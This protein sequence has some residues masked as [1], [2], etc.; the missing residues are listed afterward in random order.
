MLVFFKVFYLKLFCCMRYIVVFIK[1]LTIYNIYYNIS[2]I[3][4]LNS[5]HLPFSFIQVCRSLARIFC[6]TLVNIIMFDL[7]NWFISVHKHWKLCHCSP[8]GHISNLN[9]KLCA[10]YHSPWLAYQFK[11][12][13]RVLF[14]SF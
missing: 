5:L 7:C 3:S 4:Y 10:P 8:I 12:S 1:V 9:I 2:N 13:R 6:L 14:H 11:Y